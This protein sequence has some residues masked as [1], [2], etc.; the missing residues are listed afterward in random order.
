LYKCIFEVKK[1]VKVKLMGCQAILNE[2]WIEA[3]IGTSDID[4]EHN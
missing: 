2:I 1:C 4:A 3:K